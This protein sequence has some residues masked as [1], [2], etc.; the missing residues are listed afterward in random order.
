MDYPW[1]SEIMANVG[2]LLTLISNSPSPSLCS[3]GQV[4][5]TDSRW[6]DGIGVYY[7]HS[8]HL[9]MGMG[10][11]LRRTSTGMR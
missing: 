6:A 3:Q 9:H 2:S 4:L 10:A 7:D 11:V 5:S 8:E 1:T